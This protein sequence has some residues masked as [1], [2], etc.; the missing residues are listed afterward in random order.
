[1]KNEFIYTIKELFSDVLK[2][3]GLEKYYIGPYQRGY[4]WASSSFYDPVPQLLMDVYGAMQKKKSSPSDKF[5]EYYLQYITVL[6]NKERK[7]YEVIDGQ[8]RITTLAIIFDCFHRFDSGLEALTHNKVEYS[9]EESSLRLFDKLNAIAEGNALEDTQDMDYIKGA[10]ESI[11]LFLSLL[12]ENGLHHEYYDYLSNSVKIILNRENDFVK[13]EE[14]FVNLN[15]NKVE[16]TNAYL[17][18]GLLL[19]YGVTR[20]DAHDIELSYGDIMEQRKI[21]GRLWDEMQNFFTRPDVSHFFFGKE[22]VANEKGMEGFLELVLATHDANEN[23][24]DQDDLTKEF[25]RKLD[26]QTA[27]IRGEGFQ[28]FNRYNEKIA[29]DTEG[30]FWMERIVH[31]YKKLTG[32]YASTDL[33]NRLGFILF[34]NSNDD[35]PSFKERIET[36]KPLLEMSESQLESH[37][38]RRLLEIIPNLG[39]IEIGYND[40]RLTPLLLSFSV[41]PEGMSKPVKFDYISYDNEKWSYEHIRP[42]NPPDKI[43]FPENVKQLVKEIYLEQV[44]KKKLEILKK[45]L[46]LP[47]Q[48]DDLEKIEASLKERDKKTDEVLSKIDEGQEIEI[49]DSDSEFDFLYAELDDIDSMGNMAL[50][51]GGVNSSIKN[52]PYAV[53]RLAIFRKLEEGFFIPQHTISIFSKAINPKGAD[54]EQHFSVNQLQWDDNDVKAHAQW[55]KRRNKEIRTQLS[56]QV[57]NAE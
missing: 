39:E 24:A 53:K 15:E 48:Q 20:K 31:V 25:K 30:R 16:L 6:K 57:E 2:N 5:N 26:E 10:V 38:N 14:V 9:R 55:M 50:L 35:K 49:S 3:E 36:L 27:S 22:Y 7:A 44:D 42:Q 40:K 13:P 46:P 37:L 23:N 17:I 41:Y 29:T 1:M 8:Q 52:D 51:P 34:T 32:I 54:T 19:T 12:K 47:P 11:N 33:Y 45:L 28:L 43:K 21:S 4:K 56:N 18:K